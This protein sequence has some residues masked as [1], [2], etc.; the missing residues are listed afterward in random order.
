M[1][2]IIETL[3]GKFSVYL[4]YAPMPNDT[5]LESFKNTINKVGVED[6]SKL[7]KE[8]YNSTYA[9]GGAGIRVTLSLTKREINAL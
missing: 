2:H 8:L 5:I 6:E 7:E 4:S 9:P 1:K 3:Y